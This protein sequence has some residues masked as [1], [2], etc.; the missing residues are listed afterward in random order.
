M[1]VVITKKDLLSWSGELWGIFR[2]EKKWIRYR[3]YKSGALDFFYF[4]LN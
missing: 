1:K 2:F 4:S 3:T